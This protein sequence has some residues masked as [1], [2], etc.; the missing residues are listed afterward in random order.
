[1]ATSFEISQNVDS[2]RYIRCDNVSEYLN[3]AEE[4]ELFTKH[5][6]GKCNSVS[7]E[8]QKLNEQALSTGEG[9]VISE[10]PVKYGKIVRFRT[11]IGYKTAVIVLNA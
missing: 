8:Q 7:N 5:I 9:E 3:R 10:F 11:T 1:M 2:G 6:S 4:L